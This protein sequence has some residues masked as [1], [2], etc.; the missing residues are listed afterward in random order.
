MEAPTVLF[1]DAEICVVDKPVGMPVHADG[2]SAQ[3]TVVDWFLA[4]VPEARGVGEVQTANDGTPLERSGVVHRLDRDTSGVLLLAKTQPAYDHLKM[5]FHDRLVKKEYRALVYGHMNERWGSVDRP[6]GRSA[7]DWRRRSAERGAK[8]QLREAKTD[9]ERIGQGEYEGEPFA[10]LKLKP[11]T[12]RT[13][14]LRVHMKA[15]DRP[16]VGDTLYAG[17]K[18]EQ[19]NNLGL[20]RLALHAH[21]LELM[22][23]TGEVQRWIAPIPP[24]LEQA[25]DQLHET[26]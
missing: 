2:G 6:I 5:Q 4:R 21:V 25:I 3:P 24:V 8:G 14:Q 20:E 15:I 7:K 10:Y 12:G 26:A 22:L 23:P 13:H 19:S 9:W 17:A 18:L 16:I 11:H 1:E